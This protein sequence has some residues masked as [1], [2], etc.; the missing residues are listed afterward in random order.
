MSA[1]SYCMKTTADS[2]WMKQNNQITLDI[3]ETYIQYNIFDTDQ[4]VVDSNN[5]N[6]LIDNTES[7]DFN[8][9][10]INA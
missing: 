3:N 6:T 1:F 5:N 9:L 4:S 10:T 7:L 2:S 8:K